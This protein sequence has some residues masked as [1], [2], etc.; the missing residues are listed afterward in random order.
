MSDLENSKFF[1]FEHSIF[2]NFD[3]KNKTYDSLKELLIGLNDSSE[4]KVNGRKSRTLFH[5][6]NIIEN[7]SFNK[8]RKLESEYSYVYNNFIIVSLISL[9]PEKVDNFET[10]K[11]DVLIKLIFGRFFIENPF[12]VAKEQVFLMVN[13]EG[14]C[15]YDHVR[16]FYNY[17]LVNSIKSDKNRIILDSSHFSNIRYDCPGINNIPIIINIYNEKV[18][19]L[20]CAHLEYSLKYWFT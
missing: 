13:K 18:I 6:K 3:Y 11:F 8:F 10:I 16:I 2:A 5:H 4:K 15:C 17:Q 1:I 19:P 14:I 20:I 9:K 7:I 12:S